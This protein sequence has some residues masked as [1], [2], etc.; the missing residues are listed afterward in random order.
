MANDGFQVGIIN[1]DGD[2]EA[3]GTLDYI[4]SSGDIVIREESSGDTFR[5]DTS[6]G[7]WRADASLRIQDGTF[8]HD[9]T[10]VS[11]DITTSGDG[12]YSVDSSGSARTVTLASSDA[13]DGQEINVKRNGGNTVT[14]DTEGS[15]TIDDSSTYDLSTDN[16]TVTVIYNSENTDWE[17]Y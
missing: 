17:V 5:Y 12:Y 9:R 6:A 14:V 4:P 8:Q 1:Q 10:T 7:V 2:F 16:E 3:K 13:N 15:E 11:S